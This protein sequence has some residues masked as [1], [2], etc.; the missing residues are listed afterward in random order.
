MLA[1]IASGENQVLAVFVA[2]P[3]YPYI[4][5]PFVVTREIS[6]TFSC[7]DGQVDI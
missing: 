5:Y 6:G 3:Y 4:I 7:K 1:I 2:M